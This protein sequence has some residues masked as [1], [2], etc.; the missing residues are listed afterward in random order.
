MGQGLA[1]PLVAQV[2]AAHV[3]LGQEDGRQVAAVVEVDGP[4]RRVAEAL[5]VGQR[6]AGAQ[7]HVDLAGLQRH[8]ARRVGDELEHDALQVGLALLPVVGVALQP[9]M[10]ALDPFLEHKGPGADRRQIGRVVQHIGAGIQVPG[11]DLGA[12]AVDV[13]EQVGRG[14]GQADHHRV[15]VRRLDLLDVGEGGTAEGCSFFQ[16]LSRVYSTSAG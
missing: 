14:R 3:E 1:H 8:G 6:D 7:G 11:Q 9:H 15:L 16:T 10:A 2:G 4:F 13:V 5:E 12:V